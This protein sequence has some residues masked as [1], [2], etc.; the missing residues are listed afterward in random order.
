VRGRIVASAVAVAVLAA[1]GLA[2]ADALGVAQGPSGG[3]QALALARQPAP[4]LAGTTLDG[5][6]FD[7]ASLRGHPVLVTV[8]ASW[9][10]PCRTELPLLAATEKRLAPSGLRWVGV[11]TRDTPDQG[12]AMLASTGAAAMTSVQDPDGTLAIGW[13]ITGVPETFLVDA[14]GVVRA[15]S[16]GEVMPQ[17]ISANVDPL[18]A[19]SARGA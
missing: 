5:G 3:A 17:W 13:G 8:W 9:C 6:R 2:L 12:R 4:P 14:D 15:R 11:L 18:V 1:G 7:L 19:S 10:A 16:L